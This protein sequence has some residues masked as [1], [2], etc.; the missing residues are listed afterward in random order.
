MAKLPIC[1]DIADCLFKK[2]AE[3][4]AAEDEVGQKVYEFLAQLAFMHLDASDEET[5]FRPAVI[6]ER[7]EARHW[8][9]GMTTR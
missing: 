7:S 8:M 4:H 2:A 9:I 6:W 1:H 3:R 5:P